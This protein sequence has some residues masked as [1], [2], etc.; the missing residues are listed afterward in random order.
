MY[1]HNLNPIARLQGLLALLL[2]GALGSL[3]GCGQ[4]NVGEGATTFKTFDGG[5]DVD[6]IDGGGA[7]G[8]RANDTGQPVDA[9]GVDVPPKVDVPKP[10]D[11]VEPDDVIGPKPCKGDGQCVGVPVGTCEAAVCAFGICVA[12]AAAEGSACSDGDACTSDSVCSGGACQSGKA[13]NCDDN[14]ECTADSCLKESGCTHESNNGPCGGG[15]KC[16]GQG[17]C[18]AGKCLAG[19]VVTVRRKT[20]TPWP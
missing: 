10:D 1:Q 13:I 11:V 7:D 19:D 8:A 14:N 2:V 6:E 3:P 9:G 5:G 15:D 12:T 20:S 17:Q 4:D 16:S 18:K